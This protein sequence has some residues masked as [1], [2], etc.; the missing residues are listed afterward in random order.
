MAGFGA[1]YGCKRP[2]PDW[3]C[4][5]PFGVANAKAYAATGGTKQ[6]YREPADGFV[7]RAWQQHGGFLLFATPSSRS[8]PLPTG[9]AQAVY[10]AVHPLAFACRVLNLKVSD[11]A[12]KP[13]MLCTRANAGLTPP[14]HIHTRTHAR[15]VEDDVYDPQ[16]N[17]IE[18][19]AES[20]AVQ[21][22]V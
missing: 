11:D 7:V 19:G 17:Q 1:Q 13:A 14:W 8:L 9:L 18:Q 21:V 12:R 2:R 16:Y 6:L 4:H 15:Q 22:R 3:Y 10:S 5:C 20:N